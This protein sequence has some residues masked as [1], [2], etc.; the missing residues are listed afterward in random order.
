MTNSYAPVMVDRTLRLMGSHSIVDCTLED[1]GGS[2][3]KQSKHG[4][5]SVSKWFVK[6]EDG[7]SLAPFMSL[8]QDNHI[9]ASW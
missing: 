8:V 4:L 5:N 3:R 2:S 9:M 7:V 6:N 1:D